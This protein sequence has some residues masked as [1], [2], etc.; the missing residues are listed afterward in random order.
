MNWLNWLIAKEKVV[1]YTLYFLSV[2]SIFTYNFLGLRSFISSVAEL[3]IFAIVTL[4]GL[5]QL[6]TEQSQK[7]KIWFMLNFSLSYLLL[8]IS[9]KTDWI[10]KNLNFS[11]IFKIHLLEVPIVTVLA[12]LSISLGVF[13]L[14]SYFRIRH[15]WFL[16][17]INTILLTIISSWFFTAM[18]SLNL[19]SITE[20]SQLFLVYFLILIVSFISSF[21]FIFLNISK[22][23]NM[24]SHYTISQFLVFIYLLSIIGLP[25]NHPNTIL[26]FLNSSIR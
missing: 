6:E 15:S 2:L 14:N 24:M 20:N 8:L 22:P 12:Y 23:I 1:V 11:S 9:T 19:L 16:I 26:G 21:S 7:M 13:I 4:I 5:I 17:F 18:I 25:Q 3:I 10:I